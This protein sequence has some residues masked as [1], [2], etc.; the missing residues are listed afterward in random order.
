MFDSLDESIKHELDSESSAKDRMIRY[1]VIT[2]IAIVVIGGLYEA[3]R[4]LG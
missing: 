2:V 1:A 3:V 4:L